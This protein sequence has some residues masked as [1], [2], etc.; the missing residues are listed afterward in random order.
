[1]FRHKKTGTSAATKPLHTLTEI[2]SPKLLMG[3]EKRKKLLASIHQFSMFEEERFSSLGLPLITTLAAYYQRLP[4]TINSYYA[5]PGGLLDHALNRTDAALELFRQFLI[6]DE[7]T[8]PSTEQSL[9]IYALLT[10]SL[11][12]GIGK[13]PIEFQIT[14]HDSQG[15]PLEEWNPIIQPMLNLGQY[16]DYQFNHDI[17]ESFRARLN[18]LMAQSLM[19]P[20][21]YQWLASN[22]QVFATWLALLNED[23]GSAGILG[24]ILEYADA[25]AINRY[26]NEQF[27]QGMIA[28]KTARGTRMSTFIHRLGE[29]AIE[30]D[31]IIGLQFIQWLANAIEKRQVMLNQAP[32]LSVPGGLLLSPEIFKWFV[33]EHPEYKN[34]QA[35]QKGFLSLGLHKRNREGQ[36]LSKFSQ[37]PKSN[38]LEGV[39]FAKYAMVLPKTLPYALANQ[40]AQKI[41]A[42]EFIGLSTQ[43]GHTTRE[44]LNKMSF[45]L[46]HLATNGQW[47]QAQ[48]THPQTQPGNAFRG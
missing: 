35:V 14:L 24:A 19:P 25:L 7:K 39:V 17:A 20:S 1:M 31:E 34:W 32:L 11:L 22:K 37:E 47:Q 13:L 46:M 9:W 10:A 43:G 36:T 40:E 30:S 41:S 29:S 8:T 21:G 15:Q 27:P 2:L 4:E 6:L 23:L 48:S 16:Y 28:P 5:L 3:E 18:L 26:F 33:K 44:L 42:L 12:Q 38:I 45:G